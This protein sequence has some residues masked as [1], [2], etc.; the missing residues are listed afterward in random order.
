VPEGTTKL[1]FYCVAWKGKTVSLKFSVDGNEITTIKPVANT[2]A[3]GNPPYT[4]ITVSASN[5]YEVEMPSTDA[6]DVHVETIKG[7]DCR[8][9]IIGLQALTD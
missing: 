3:T 5:Y 7:S 6:A 8:V 1:G 2:G 9:L 4:S